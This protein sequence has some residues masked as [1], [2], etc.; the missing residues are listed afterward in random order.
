[1]RHMKEINPNGTWGQ[2][3]QSITTIERVQ[4]C[5]VTPHDYSQ[6]SNLIYQS[7]MV[8]CYTNP[9]RH[10]KNAFCVNA[11]TASTAPV[12]IFLNPLSDHLRSSS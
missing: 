1:M 12:C 6:V 10:N 4:S 9:M 5:N 7:I 2:S 3:E 11:S 8:Y